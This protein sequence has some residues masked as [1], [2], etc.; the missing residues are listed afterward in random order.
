MPRFLYLDR[1]QEPCLTRSVSD[2]KC[3]YVTTGGKS[4]ECV[5]L[6]CVAVTI[7]LG[8]GTDKPSVLEGN[9]FHV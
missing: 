6:T 1:R 8:K 4:R 9:S 3:E 5:V 7:Y 2:E